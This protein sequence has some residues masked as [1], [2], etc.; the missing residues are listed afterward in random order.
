M[1]F[2]KVDIML[3]QLSSI[4]W[5]D[6]S[7]A[8]GRADDIPPL[9]RDLASSD[10]QIR[11]D[12]LRTLYTTIYHQGSVYQAS[13]Y[14]ASFLI[15]LVQQPALADREE[16][17]ILLAYLAQAHSSYHQH[18][19]EHT[20]DPA[21]LAK[22][23][24]DVFWAERTYEAVATGIPLY[25]SLLENPDIQLRLAALFVLG[26]L[27]QEA[28]QI[29]PLLCEQFETDM[30]ERVQAS[31]LLAM[32]DLCA[33]QENGSAPAWAL[34]VQALET[35][36]TELVQVAAALALV[37]T[38]RTEIPARTYDLLLPHI[39]HPDS[40][41]EVYEELPWA[42][43]RLALQVIRS[44]YSLPPS[45]D[46]KQ[47]PRLMHFLESLAQGE[48]TGE[49]N[50]KRFIAS[51]LVDLIITLAFRE[52][53][54]GEAIAAEHLPSLQQTMLHALV[55]CDIVWRW[56]SGTT[57]KY[58]TLE[59]SGDG[60]ACHEILFEAFQSKLAG[61]GLPPTREKLRAYLGM[62]PRERDAL[63]ILSPYRD[64]WTRLHSNEK[65]QI[66]AELSAFNSAEKLADLRQIVER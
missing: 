39:R 20:Q 6:L 22:G 66:L 50:I 42:E 10:A 60:Q 35:G 31:L 17:L 43:Q 2:K 58:Q 41:N 63:R 18:S 8:Y 26:A 12:A 21:L 5:S 33:N 34:L 57:V 59:E 32:G 7:H 24:Q 14:A 36:P 40:L 38:G 61:K 45:Q 27:T 30:D 1:N 54:R 64:I 47:L 56:G 11:R 9:L 29:L 23:E 25:W 3:D 65:N 13:A 62:E 55:N 52:R 49:R 15:E 4:K 37:K 44:L 16:F 53:K 48:E 28:E 46:A 51:R 19:D